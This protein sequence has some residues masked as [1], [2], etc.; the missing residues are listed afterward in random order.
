MSKKRH[1]PSS[2]HSGNCHALFNPSTEHCN[3]LKRGRG[4][5]YMNISRD[6]M[7]RVQVESGPPGDCGTSAA[8]RTINATNKDNKDNKYNN[9]DNKDK[10]QQHCFPCLPLG[11]YL[12]TIY[13]GNLKLDIER[14]MVFE[15]CQNSSIWHIAEK[16]PHPCL[17]PFAASKLDRRVPRNTTFLH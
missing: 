3:T 9:K 8:V 11:V 1:H 15:F 13:T 2:D 16:L 14:C 10:L 17:E 4:P 6:V 12:N 7:Q 5:C